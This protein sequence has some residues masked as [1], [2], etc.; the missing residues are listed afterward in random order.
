VKY[1]SSTINGGT[2]RSTLGKLFLSAPFFEVLA[3]K[4]V[5]IN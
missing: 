2:P 4:I 3:Q 1:C 5:P